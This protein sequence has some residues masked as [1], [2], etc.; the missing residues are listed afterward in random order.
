MSWRS[1][2]EIVFDTWEKVP[3]TI[4][5]NIIPH[6]AQAT[7]VLRHNLKLPQHFETRL[8]PLKL[9]CFISKTFQPFCNWI[10]HGEFYFQPSRTFIGAGVSCQT[11]GIWHA[12]HLSVWQVSLFKIAPY[13]PNSPLTFRFI[14]VGSGLVSCAGTQI[15]TTAH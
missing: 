13:T 9:W 15:R 4:E 1:V 2:Q 3:G 7:H 8:K 10:F 6:K 5:M 11:P 12:F 14:P